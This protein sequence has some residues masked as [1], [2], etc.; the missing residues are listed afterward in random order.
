MSIEK[1]SLVKIIGNIYSLDSVLLKCCESEIFH[2][3]ASEGGIGNFKP[4]AETNPYTSALQKIT[5]AMNILSIPEKYRDCGRVSVPLDEIEEFSNDTLEQAKSSQDEIEKVKQNIDI[6][7]QAVEQIEHMQ[8]LET[9]FDDIFAS[10]Y[11]KV[12]FGRLPV[13]SYLK[14]SYFSK[15]N[16][17]FFPFEHDDS[18]YWCMYIMPAN[19]QDEIDDIFNSLYFER[20]FIPDEAHGTPEL[21]AKN[22]EEIVKA[23]QIRLSAL[24]IELDKLRKS[25][26]DKLQVFYSYVKLKHDTFSFRKYAVSTANQFHLKGFVPQCQSKQFIAM[27]DDMEQVV[28]EEQSP[29]ADSRLTPPVKLKTNWFFRPFEMFVKMYGL[30]NYTEFNPTTYIGIIYFVLFG[31]MFGD[32]GQG[33]VVSLAGYFMWK[34]MKMDLGLVLTRCGISSMFFGFLYG[35]V[36]GYEHLLDPIFKSVFGLSEKPIDVFESETTTMLLIVAI[37]IGVVVILVSMVLNIYLGLKKRD[38]QRAL[39]S[40]NGLAGLL[41]YGGVMVAVG[42]IMLL[43]INVL[44]PVFIVIFIVIPILMMFLREP[45][46]KLVKG[47]KDIKPRDGI[48]GFIVENFFELFEF[49]LSYVTNT[50]SFLRVSGFILSH[51]GMLAVVMTLSE[52]MGGIGNPIVVIFGNILVMALEGLLVGIQSLR[53]VYYET[54]SRFYEGDGKPYEPVKIEFDNNK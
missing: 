43:D 31:M 7:K 46:A 22:L 32:L 40:N 4:I 27:F 33:L 47:K 17:F 16:F 19:E 24:E 28:C 12:R 26:A 2:P 15:K 23:E 39:F 5:E 29:D 44:N 11:T 38:Y 14:L 9:K 52:M 51:T 3:E 25:S 20:I 30:P 10:K 37:A 54:F 41:F 45:L 21:A 36:F 53:L 34:V 13:D 35:S 8:G 48:G 1:M 49:M 50:I 6:T 18:F 42:L